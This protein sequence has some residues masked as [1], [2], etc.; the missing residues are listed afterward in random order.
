M[1]S[2]LRV[3]TTHTVKDLVTVEFETGGIVMVLVVFGRLLMMIPNEHV[4]L[5]VF[6]S[7]GV[8]LLGVMIVVRNRLCQIHMM[9]TSH[10]TADIFD[11]DCA[12]KLPYYQRCHRQIVRARMSKGESKAGSWLHRTCNGEREPNAHEALFWCG[13]AGPK[14]VLHIMRTCSLLVSTGESH[15]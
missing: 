5:A 15:T 4:K 14:L 1:G 6:L 12:D 3:C 11:N 10:V 8:L 9:L 2:Y 13:A 7:L